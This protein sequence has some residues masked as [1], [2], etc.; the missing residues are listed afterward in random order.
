MK[1][2][3]RREYYWIYNTENWKTKKISLG[4][5][6]GKS[7]EDVVKLKLQL[8]TLFI[9]R[10]YSLHQKTEHCSA[11]TQ[12]LR[13]KKKKSKKKSI[14]IEVIPYSYY[15]RKNQHEPQMMKF[16]TK[17]GHYNLTNKFY[18]V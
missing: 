7:V 17:N 10:G 12:F 14:S 1:T 6:D 5:G 13:I 3:I 15:N 4:Q 9:R 16:L 11:T 2:Q 18:S 8:T